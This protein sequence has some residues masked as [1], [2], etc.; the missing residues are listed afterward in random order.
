MVN[1]NFAEHIRHNKTSSDLLR[2]ILSITIYDEREFAKYAFFTA[3]Y[4][5]VADFVGQSAK[6][7][8]FCLN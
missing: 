6:N 2:F 3:K 1:K 5:A 4:T 7:E 8:L